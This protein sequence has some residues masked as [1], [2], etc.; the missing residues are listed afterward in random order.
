MTF[1]E[2]NTVEQMILDC[3]APKRDS[4][5]LKA[6]QDT[7]GWGDSLE[8]EFKPSRWDYMPA[9]HLPRKSTDVMVE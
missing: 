4:E 3:V 6:H 5:P 7:P 9:A 8:G 2:A 1:T